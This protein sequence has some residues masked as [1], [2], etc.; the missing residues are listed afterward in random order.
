MTKLPGFTFDLHENKQGQTFA[1]IL[2]QGS[3]LCVCV[4]ASQPAQPLTWKFIYF[5]M[6]KL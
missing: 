1:L 2:H 6:V 4:P 5:K 3:G